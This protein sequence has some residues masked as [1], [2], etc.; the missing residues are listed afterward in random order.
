MSIDERI[1]SLIKEEIQAADDGKKFY[2][3]G[4][5]DG[6]TANITVVANCNSNG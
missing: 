1:K 2:I 3:A 6:L 4:V 5:L